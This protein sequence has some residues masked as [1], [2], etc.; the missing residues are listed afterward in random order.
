M[1]NGGRRCSRT[2]TQFVTPLLPI[3]CLI[4]PAPPIVFSSGVAGVAGKK[5]QGGCHEQYRQGMISSS[6]A[7]VASCLRAGIVSTRSTCPH[8]L[9]RR[10]NSILCRLRRTSAAISRWVVAHSGLH[11]SEAR[12]VLPIGTSRCPGVL[13]TS[14][15][16][17]YAQDSTERGSGTSSRACATTAAA[18]T[19]RVELL[20]GI[21]GASSRPVRR[22]V[23]IG[24]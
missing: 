1:R 14:C 4:S 13:T 6:S 19:G 7:H 21:E 20:T 2:L 22:I 15:C 18:A 16:A 11:V 24:G 23:L 12:N 17:N 10:R 8:L 5:G 3:S 9:C